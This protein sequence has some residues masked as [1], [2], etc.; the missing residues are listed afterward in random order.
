M[1]A[2]APIFVRTISRFD[3]ADTPE[4]ARLR[5]LLKSR[6]GH[7]GRR[8]SRFSLLALAAA[9]PLREFLQAPRAART[10]IWLGAPFSSPARFES[11]LQVVT[12]QS[13]AK[14][15]DFIGNIHNAACFHVAQVL[16]LHGPSLFVA[17]GHDEP[18]VAQPLLSALLDLRTGAMD[19]ALVGWCVERQA[20][21][22]LN[23]GAAADA[24]HQPESSAPDDT[25]PAASTTDDGCCWWLLSTTPDGAI[26][27]IDILD[28]RDAAP[29]VAAASTG[30]QILNPFRLACQHQE[31]LAQ[32]AVIEIPA[33]L[34]LRL[35]LQRIGTAAVQTGTP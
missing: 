5:A 7:D 20:A 13:S 30:L 23:A 18:S 19:T 21:S 10:G 2:T 17:V 27:Q 12:G 1:T 28:R 22:G 6:H 32:H 35:R 8:L 26:A 33:P 14:P 34:G 11:M 4:D 31:R 16:G 25:T 24:G 29:S 3:G 15:F 9:L